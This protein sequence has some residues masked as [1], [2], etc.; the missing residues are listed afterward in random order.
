MPDRS[1]W[2]TKQLS[3]ESAAA[4]DAVTKRLKECQHNTASCD[5][6]S[7]CSKQEIYTFHITTALG[8]HSYFGDGFVLG[9]DR[10]TA[11]HL[12]SLLVLAIDQRSAASFSAIV[13]DSAANC[14]KARR[15]VTEEFPW[16]LDIPDACHSLQLLF[17]DLCSGTNGTFHEVSFNLIL[18][19]MMSCHFTDVNDIFCHRHHDQY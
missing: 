17:K 13:T 11:D 19:Y 4:K 15:L 9:G 8:H 5:G 14:K 3:R 18:A 1:A 7:T 6:W 12:K 10:A 16:I 2:V